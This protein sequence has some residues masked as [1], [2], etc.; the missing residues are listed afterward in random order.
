MGN[1]WKITE[2]ELM[3]GEDYP[4]ERHRQNAME[5]LRK[6]N[7]VRNQY[8]KQMIITSGYRNPVH[9]AKIGGAKRSPHMECKAMDIR[10]ASGELSAWLLNHIELLRQIGLYMENPSFTRG[11]VHL[12]TVER[13]NTIFNP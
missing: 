7:K 4:S 8:G 9:N 13:K 5:L 10:D 6:V 12:D 2:Y 1:E 11:W 3:H